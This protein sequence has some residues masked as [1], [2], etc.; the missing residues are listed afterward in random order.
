VQA[1]MAWEKLDEMQLRAPFAGQPE[2]SPSEPASM[3]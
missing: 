2:A 3:A 1:L